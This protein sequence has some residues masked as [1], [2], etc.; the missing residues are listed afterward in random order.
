MHQQEK[1]QQLS[2]ILSGYG[3]VGIAFSGGADSS[4]LLKSAL[5]VL[6]AGNVCIL[7]AKSCLLTHQENDQAA[8]WLLRHGYSADIV[9]HEIALDPLSWQEFVLNPKDRCYRCKR[10]MYSLFLEFL[11]CRGITYLLDGTNIDDLKDRRPGLR[12]IHELDVQT[13]LVEAGLGK[14]E[15]RQQ[16]KALLLDTYDLPTSSCLATRLPTGLEITRARLEKISRWEQKIA[17]LGFGGCRV[18]ISS[19]SEKILYL[20]VMRVDLDRFLHS[21][22]RDALVRYFKNQEIDKI[23]LDLEGR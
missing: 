5:D 7:H 23:F 4:F 9:I 21:G 18:K 19:E 1:P 13:P 8:S 6:G 22:I 10:R 16:S 14:H 3:R 2:D 12:A 11:E 15:I 17:D 20:Q